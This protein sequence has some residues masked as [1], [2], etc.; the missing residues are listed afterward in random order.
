[1]K[2]RGSLPEKQKKRLTRAEQKIVR[3]YNRERQREWLKKSN[4]TKESMDTEKKSREQERKDR[5]GQAEKRGK[6]WNKH[7]KAHANWL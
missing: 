2:E 6:W 5:C 3:D 7:T 4:R 1:M